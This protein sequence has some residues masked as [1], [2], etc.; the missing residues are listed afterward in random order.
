MKVFLNKL[1][2]KKELDI[3]EVVLDKLLAVPA[4]FYGLAVRI[5]GI[6]YDYYIIKS[7]KADAFVVSI[8]N[9]T[10][11]GTGKTPITAA[12]AN[13]Y[14]RKGEKVAILSRGYGS[15]LEHRDIHIISHEGKICYEADIAGDEPVW[16]AQNCP[17]VSVLTCSSRVRIAKFAVEKLGATVLVMDD[18]FQHRRLKRDLNILVV[19]S[20]KVFGNEKLLPR[21][22]L[23]EPLKAIKRADKIILVNKNNDENV[24][25]VKKEL[26]KRLSKPIFICKMKTKEI[27]NEKTGEALKKQTSVL[28]FSAIAQP[29][30]FYAYLKY[31]C[32]LL[33]T[34]DFA[35]HHIYTKDDADMILDLAKKSGASAVVTTEK[36]YVKLKT[37]SDGDF[38]VL[39]LKAEL[40]PEKILN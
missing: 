14:A 19:D 35:D 36:D 20:E 31:D 28:A 8:G 6:L 9:I 10:T 1:H 2:Y 16:L 3:K 33:K 39:K 23:R 4:W 12:I 18:G 24:A 21:G 29:E 40:D 5:R 26:E 13:F 30:Q 15:K 34:I 37:V 11:G 7:Y 22:A 27:V 25:V 32:K 17:E 38:Y